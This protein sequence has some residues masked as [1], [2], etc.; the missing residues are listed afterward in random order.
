MEE[1]RARLVMERKEHAAALEAT[2]SQL[3]TVVVESASLK[4][5]EEALRQDDKRQFR[6]TVEAL[7]KQLSE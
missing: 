7:E 6:I 5:A 4:G 1:L 2:E 3:T